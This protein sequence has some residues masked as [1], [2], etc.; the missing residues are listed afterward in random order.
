M[1]HLWIHTYWTR[2]RLD[3]GWFGTGPRDIQ[4]FSI[5]SLGGHLAFS[6]N[7]I[8]F[9]DQDAFDKVAKKVVQSHFYFSHTA[10][11]QGRLALDRLG[12]GYSAHNFLSVPPAPS[13]MLIAITIPDWLPTVLFAFLPTR[14]AVLAWL[15]SRR[16]GV[17]QCSFCGYSLTGNTSGVC[18]E[19]G[20]T[21][22]KKRGHE[23][24]TGIQLP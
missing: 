16:F 7:D 21:I 3:V 8:S 6:S 10:M 20:T 11:P 22:E 13:Q 17:G 24:K 23:I 9:V 18:P 1:A 2:Y 14:Y 5:D 19:C 12:F 15:K 4:I